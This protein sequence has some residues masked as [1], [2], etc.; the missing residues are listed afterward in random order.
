MQ[1]ITNRFGTGFFLTYNDLRKKRIHAVS[2]A[3]MS[4]TTD[5][6]S[7]MQKKIVE[8]DMHFIAKPLNQEDCFIIIL[9]CQVTDL[10]ILNDIKTAEEYHK[11]YPE[12]QIVM[13]GCLAYRFDIPLPDWCLRVGTLRQE[14]IEISSNKYKL[15]D[16][17]KPFGVG[18]NDKDI[19][20]MES[21]KLFRNHYPLKIGAGCHGKCKYC[22]IRDTRGES[23]EVE[24]CQQIDE[25]LKYSDS[26]NNE[27]DGVVLISDSPTV[28]Q[29]KD[30]CSIALYYNRKISFRNVEPQIANACADE[31]LELAKKELLE[32]FHCPI[33][34]NDEKVLTTMGRSVKAT[35]D[36]IELAQKL[37]AKKR[38]RCNQ[39]YHRL[40]SRR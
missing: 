8:P 33:Q 20:S 25:F 15:L 29:I 2:T 13:G 1:T 14:N 6:F 7:F 3:C 24:A 11:E 5:M 21:G 31:L 23:F 38:I 4:V 12:A 27:Y 19:F 35:F 17:K 16:W 32:I 28:K 30:W 39:Y 34:S 10:S 9:G 18:E 37:R 22:T 36:Y 26:Y 40:Y